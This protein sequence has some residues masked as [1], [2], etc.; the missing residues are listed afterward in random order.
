MPS[1]SF[2]KWAVDSEEVETRVAE[3]GMS[4]DDWIADEFYS[5][6]G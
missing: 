4:T 2:E 6:D 1:E 3:A 5:N